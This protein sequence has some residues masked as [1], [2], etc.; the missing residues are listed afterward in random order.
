MPVCVFCGNEFGEDRPGFPLRCKHWLH[1]QHCPLQFFATATQPSCCGYHYENVTE[2][3]SLVTNYVH[4]AFPNVI[5][6]PK[7]GEEHKDA[8]SAIAHTLFSIHLD[9]REF[10]STQINGDPTN[11]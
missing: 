8:L 4:G 10:I 11:H 1:L 7:F 9:E 6:P 2:L 3:V 5:L